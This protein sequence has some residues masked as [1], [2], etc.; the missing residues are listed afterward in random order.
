MTVPTQNEKLDKQASSKRL[1][2]NAQALPNFTLRQP[3][4]LV[5]YQKLRDPERECWEWAR[6]LL[7]DTA[8]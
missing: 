4:A 3:R 5:G 1:P 2:Q 8:A 6:I 7:K